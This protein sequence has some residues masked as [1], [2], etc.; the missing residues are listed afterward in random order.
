VFAFY[1]VFGP[2]NVCG[3]I[4]KK[5][6]TATIIITTPTPDATQR[7]R[8]KGAKVSRHFIDGNGE[9]EKLSGPEDEVKYKR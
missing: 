2:V 7:G 8:K 9:V 4:N 1:V 3:Q 6:I 5:Q